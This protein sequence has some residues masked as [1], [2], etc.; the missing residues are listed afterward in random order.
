MVVDLYQRSARSTK[1]KARCMCI[2]VHYH[3]NN[4]PKG[5]N[6]RPQVYK[7]EGH[8][9]N[10]SS[11]HNISTA[12]QTSY[13]KLISISLHNQLKE[14][15]ICFQR[16]NYQ[17]TYSCGKGSENYRAIIIGCFDIKCQYEA[18]SRAFAWQINRLY[19]RYDVSNYVAY[20]V[21]IQ[22][23]LFLSLLP[24]FVL[25]WRSVLHP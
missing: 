8:Q 1:S 15:T 16:G 19:F 13:S 11:H 23:S 17:T 10:A 2:F 21:H 14:I 25:N 9:K 20:K 12:F 24:I 6:L 7:N 22:D 3:H 4:Q 18:C 5:T